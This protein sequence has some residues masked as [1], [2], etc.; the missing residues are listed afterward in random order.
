MFLGNLSA[1]TERQARKSSAKSAL[2]VLFD[3]NFF[4]TLTVY[5]GL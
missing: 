5:Y 2:K 1:N 3:P 4:S